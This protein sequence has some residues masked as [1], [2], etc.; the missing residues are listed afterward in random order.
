[1][2]V[3]MDIRR[4]LT[5]LTVVLAV[6]LPAGAATITGTYTYDGVAVAT[7]YSDLTGATVR[8]YDYGTSGT[9]WG[10][11]DTAAE[12]F[13][14]ENV[15]VGQDVLVQIE[16][17]RSQPSDNDGFDGGDLIGLRVV[18]IVSDSDTIDVSIHMRSVVHFTSPFDSEASMSA[19]F[20]SCPVGLATASPATVRWDAVPNATS[21]SV[22]V[23]RHRCDHSIS[24]QILSQQSTTEIAV[25][26]GTD[27]EDHVGIW[28][29]CFGNAAT[30]LCFMPYIEM[31]DTTVQAYVFR[32]S[33]GGGS[34]RGTDH[35][36]GFFIPVVARTSG[37]GT[38]VWSAI[39]PETLPVQTAS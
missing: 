5:T 23:R 38:S 18:T 39:H 22:Y 2:E 33:G 8:T 17:D 15:P 11:V 10:T 19:D 21:Y 12:T 4:T 3:E 6:C 20:N 25:T 30:N 28:L 14:I 9:V 26:L 32:E 13:R 27:S 16:L 36:D 1:M 7:V 34:G 35:T 37:V 24:S 29:E 31:Q